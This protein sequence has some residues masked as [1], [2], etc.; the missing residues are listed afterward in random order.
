PC[1]WDGPTRRQCRCG[2]LDGAN[3]AP[4]NAG[5]FQCRR[6][7]GLG[8]LSEGRLQYGDR[9]L[10]RSFE[11]EPRG[12]HLPLSSW[13]GLSKGQATGPREATPRTGAEDQPQIHQRR[14]GKK[15]FGAIGLGG[16]SV[17]ILRAWGDFRFFRT[18]VP[19]EG[20]HES[21]RNPDPQC[22]T[23]IFLS[24]TLELQCGPVRLDRLRTNRRIKERLRS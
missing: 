5:L 8:L 22:L 23:L 6:Y 16:G 12:S 10:Q 2:A 15:G 21:V 24:L 3:R 19:L 13:T 1:V 14:R 4:C 20:R 17:A 18:T 9:S 11:E 7:F